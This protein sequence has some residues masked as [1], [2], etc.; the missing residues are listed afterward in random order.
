MNQKNNHSKRKPV[1]TLLLCFGLLAVLP[2]KSAAARKPV[3]VLPFKVTPIQEKAHHWLGRAVSFYL[4]SGL[5]HNALPVL[6][7]Q[8]TA[9]I[10]EMN[11]IMFPYNITKASVIRL[12][13]ENQLDRVIWGKIIWAAIQAMS[14]KNPLSNCDHLSLI[15]RIFPKN[16]CL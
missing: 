3:L 7:D 12:A 1:F 15:R 9:S 6:P 13:R 14:L 5:Q 4:T 2:G 10:L 8:H 16:I 11:H